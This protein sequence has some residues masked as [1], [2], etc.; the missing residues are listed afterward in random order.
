MTAY[1][2]YVDVTDHGANI[3]NTIDSTAGINSAIQVAISRMGSNSISTSG[4]VVFFPAGRFAVSG[5]LDLSAFQSKNPA[6]SRTLVLTGEGPGLS[7]LKVSSASTI[8]FAM[9]VSNSSS[10]SVQYV[11]QLTLEI[12]NMSIDMSNRGT[13]TVSGI[14]ISGA[15][16]AGTFLNAA[17]PA[18]IRNVTFVE[19]SS[20]ALTFNY[21]NSAK[22]DK[23]NV[24][25][26]GGVTLNSCGNLR[27]SDSLIIGTSGNA[28][29]ISSP[30]SNLHQ[31][32]GVYLSNVEVDI[33]SI[34]LQISNTHFGTCSNCSFTSCNAYGLKVVNTGSS[35]SAA[36]KFVGCEFGASTGGGGAAA[37]IYDA[38]TTQLLFSS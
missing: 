28:I 18:L 17:G 22:I 5:S 1:S 6:Y 7:I 12:S 30:D 26:G 32:E 20:S 23:I 19:A 13:H 38:N 14:E 33:S 15:A 10:A 34:G 2:D 31:S 27:F 8:Y 4:A 37:V 25:G 3:N 11:N 29:E 35:T 36:W 21:V 16:D 9:I 24:I